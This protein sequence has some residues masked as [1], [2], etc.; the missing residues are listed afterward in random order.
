M[1]ELPEI[2]E[3]LP[4]DEIE[5]GIVGQACRAGGLHVGHVS[6]RHSMRTAESSCEFGPISMT[7]VPGS[8]TA[9]GPA[10]RSAR[11]YVRSAVVTV[12]LTCRSSP[13]CS[14]IFLKFLSSRTG[15]DRLATGSPT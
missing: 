2:G 6:A 12:K 11:K 8:K 1:G 13:G 9:S 3:R 10:R 4:L 15:R 7:K 5:Q 14:K